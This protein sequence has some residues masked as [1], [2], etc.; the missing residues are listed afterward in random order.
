MHKIIN[1]RAIIDR[2]KVISRLDALVAEDLTRQKRRARVLE[3]LKQVV[4]EGFAEVRSRFDSH[5]RGT[6]AVR[7]NCFMID[8]LVRVVHDFA[9]DHEFGPGVRT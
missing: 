7:E 5:C 3:I 4:A 6:E 8:Q 9:V 2:R 1:Q